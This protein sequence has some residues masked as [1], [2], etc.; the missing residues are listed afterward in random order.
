[1]AGHEFYVGEFYFKN[2]HYKAA[3]LR[4]RAVVSNYPDVGFT[5]KS[6][7]YIARCEAEL[8]REEPEKKV[9][10]WRLWRAPSF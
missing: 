8:A 10:W 5:Q 4:F 2:K 1:M 9:S 7:E 6:L 3:V